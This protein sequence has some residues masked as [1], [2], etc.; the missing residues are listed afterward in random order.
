MPVVWFQHGC[1]RAQLRPGH[2]LVR[3][4]RPQEPPH[5]HP[6][7]PRVLPVLGRSFRDGLRDLQV[8]S[9]L[10]TLSDQKLLR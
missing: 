4:P 10:Q 8:P 1:T 2:S 5:V 6:R 3:R 7:L 9:G